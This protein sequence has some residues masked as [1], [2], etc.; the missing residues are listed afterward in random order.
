M[1][2]LT[3]EANAAVAAYRE[4][5]R[6]IVDLQYGIGEKL[7]E[8]RLVTELGYGRSP[9]RTALARLKSEGW[10][11]VSPQSGTYVKALTNRDIEEVTELRLL[12]EMHS[13]REAA[14]KISAADLE[15]LRNSFRAL[16]PGIAAGDIEGFIS[17]DNKLHAAIYRA[18]GNELVTEILMNLRDKV[19]WIRRACAVSLERVQEG[20][21]ELEQ[22]LAALEARN[23]KAAAE[24]MRLHIYNAAAFCKNIEHAPRPAEPTRVQSDA[25]RGHA[26]APERPSVGR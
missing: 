25:R 22:I 18:A 2:P 9:I 21:H 12:L 10:I 3:D 23:T 14:R 17:I 11:A 5:K 16:G 15:A 24:S 8:A 4:I 26:P 6:R 19:Q 13:A 7:S 20:F 1:A